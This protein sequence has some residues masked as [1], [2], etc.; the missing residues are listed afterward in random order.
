[1]LRII[2]EKEVQNSGG[3]NLE[4]LGVKNLKRRVRWRGIIKEAQSQVGLYG[5]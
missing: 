4:Q 3:K 2:E 1:M 5:R